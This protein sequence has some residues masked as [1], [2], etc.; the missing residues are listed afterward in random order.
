MISIGVPIIMKK[1]LS[2]MLISISI[3]FT[4]SH[5]CFASRHNRDSK[6]ASFNS[7]HVSAVP[8]NQ[9]EEPHLKDKDLYRATTEIFS[10]IYRKKATLEKTTTY[11]SL[12]LVHTGLSLFWGADDVTY[13]C[14]QGAL[15]IGDKIGKFLPPNVQPSF[16]KTLTGI[17]YCLEGVRFYRNTEKYLFEQVL[18]YSG[19][20]I[21]DIVSPYTNSQNSIYQQ[22]AEALIY[23]LLKTVGWYGSDFLN[24][25]NNLSEEPKESLE[26]SD[27]LTGT[28]K[29]TLYDTLESAY[30]AAECCEPDT[31]RQIRELGFLNQMQIPIRQ[32]HLLTDGWKE[33]I[34]SSFIADSFSASPGKVVINQRQYG[35]SNGNVTFITGDIMK[36]VGLGLYNTKEN[37]CGL[38]HIDGENIRFFDSYLEGKTKINSFLQYLFDVAG[39]SSFETIQATIVG[40][41]SAHINYMIAYLKSFGVKE[42]RVV[43]NSE[44]GRDSNNYFNDQPKGSLAINCKDG[45][46]WEVKNEPTV[47][48][49]MGVPPLGDGIPRPLLK[50]DYSG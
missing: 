40:G 43:H 25:W 17:S 32:C 3:L 49:I 18:G 15:V 46:V 38:T 35:V 26:I 27:S 29:K 2:Y 47:R 9:N 21:M 34:P 6:K 20:F 22:E 42:F 33:L 24:G 10:T 31:E 30:R 23:Y 44:W 5:E 36:C 11:R 19:L 8:A 41:S 1:K 28:E 16:S 50:V 12:S 14:M 39:T 45:R 7:R 4:T 13:R 48:E 37:R